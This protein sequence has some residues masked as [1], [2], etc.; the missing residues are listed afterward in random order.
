[1]GVA[2]HLALEVVAAYERRVQA[3]N[4]QHEEAPEKPH[5]GPHPHVHL[6]EVD[7]EV[8]QLEPV[9]LQQ[10]EEEGG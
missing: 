9:G 2:L 7:E 5:L 1:V 6:A 10:R 3:H 4:L 8:M